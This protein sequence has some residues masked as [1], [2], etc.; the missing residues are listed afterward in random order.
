MSN[1]RSEIS[2]RLTE[3]KLEY[4]NLDRFFYSNFKICAENFTSYIKAKPYACCE[5]SRRVDLVKRHISEL[6][7]LCN[8]HTGGWLDTEE[9]REKDRGHISILLQIEQDV[10]KLISL[11]KAYEVKEL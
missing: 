11:Y 7:R 6:W 9:K 3:L 10:N 8:N 1:N 2:R 4:E 5:Y